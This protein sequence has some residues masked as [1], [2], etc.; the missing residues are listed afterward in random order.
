MLKLH[1]LKREIEEAREESEA[2]V[3]RAERE[4]SLQRHLNSRLNRVQIELD[5]MT[6]RTT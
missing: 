4:K 2:A 1:K 6:R 3:K 5:N